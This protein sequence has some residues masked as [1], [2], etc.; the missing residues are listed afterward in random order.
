MFNQPAEQIGSG[1]YFTQEQGKTLE[2]LSGIS[3][4]PPSN[5][6]IPLPPITGALTTTDYSPRSP[7]KPRKNIDFKNFAVLY[8]LVDVPTPSDKYQNKTDLAPSGKVIIPIPHLPENI[9]IF[10]ENTYS[11]DSNAATPDGIFVYTSTSPLKIPIEFT[12]HA[13]DDLCPEGAYT[14]LDLA[15]RFQALLLPVSNEPDFGARVA[16]LD[17]TKDLDTSENGLDIRIKNTAATK[18]NFGLTSSAALVQNNQI[19][20]PPACGLKLLQASNS[21]FGIKC[22]GFIESVKIT[23][24]GPYLT[25]VAGSEVFNLPSSA[26]YNFTFVHNPWY[27]NKFSKLMRPVFAYGPDVFEN[28]YNTVHLTQL[29]NNSYY[30]IENVNSERQNLTR[31]P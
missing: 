11:G 16:A 31:I 23:L 3:L 2:V 22:V 17:T 30:D 8:S 21:G 6:E 29:A 26:T 24:H 1:P 4:T 19:K 18:A 10:R 12:L 27:T 13:W 28:F 20:F 5:T 25:G 14:L 15:A 9:D 7:T